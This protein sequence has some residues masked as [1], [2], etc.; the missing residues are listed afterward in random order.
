MTARLLALLLLALASGCSTLRPDMSQLTGVELPEGLQ[1]PDYVPTQL[2]A[3]EDFQ[4]VQYYCSKS[5]KRQQAAAVIGGAYLA[6]A[7]STV[8][9]RCLIVTWTHTAYQL[10]GHE[11]LHCLW[12]PR[13]RAGKTEGI[14]PHFIAAPIRAPPQ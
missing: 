13:T 2:V 7:I 4:K 8:D 1:A 3:F 5:D 10:V 6:C 9:D 11:V 14:P 12:T